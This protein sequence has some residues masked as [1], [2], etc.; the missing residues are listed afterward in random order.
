MV[1]ITPRTILPTYS[2]QAITRVWFTTRGPHLTIFTWVTGLTPDMVLS[3]AIHL[4]RVIHHGII[5]MVSMVTIHH[6][7]PRAITVITGDLTGDIVV[8]QFSVDGNIMANVIPGTISRI[9]GT[10]AG[11]MKLV[12]NLPWAK[13]LLSTETAFLPHAISLLHRPVT[14]VTRVWLS[15]ATT[16]QRQE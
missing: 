15:G 9:A 3:M 7:I 12:G 2:I 11:N 13:M 14:P 1:F 6:G 10:V 16:A 4:G 8:V 5:R